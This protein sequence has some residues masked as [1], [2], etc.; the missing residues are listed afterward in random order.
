[1]DI[2][3]TRKVIEIEPVEEPVSVPAEPAPEELPVPAAAS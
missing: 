2:G 1:M 3:R